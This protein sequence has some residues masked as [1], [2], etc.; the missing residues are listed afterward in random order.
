MDTPFEEWDHIVKIDPDKSL[1]EGDTFEDVCNTGTDAI[2]IGGTTGISEDKMER[3]VEAC[4]EFDIP[5]YIEPSNI[6]SV[7]HR[8]EIDGY[9]VPVVF[10][11]GDVFW[12]TGAHKEWARVETNLDWSR[13]F[14][15]AYVILN[16]DSAVANYTEADCD[17]ELEDVVAYAEVAEHLFGQDIF[18]IEYSGMFGDPEI[19]Q[20]AKD[21]IDKMSVFY[22]GGIHD[23]DQAYE[24]ATWADTIVVGDL[25]HD[26]GAAAVEQTVAGAK[27]A[28][29]AADD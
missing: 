5:V 23:Y 18:Y 24:M 21:T 22:G 12:T 1:Y 8:R 9:L 28:K 25:I 14:T 17:L 26:Q 27:A 20:A 10:N 29:S 13:I 6:N 16:P 11:A 2:E 3:V 4:A 7:L 15:E 19:V